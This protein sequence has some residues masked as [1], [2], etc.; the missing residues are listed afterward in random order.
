VKLQLK[1]REL[2]EDLQETEILSKEAE[3][4]LR[5]QRF[6]YVKKQTKR[7]AITEQMEGAHFD[8][9]NKLKKQLEKSDRDLKQSRDN[10]ILNTNVK[11][12]VDLLEKDV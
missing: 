3:S 2:E 5:R 10:S 12:T 11:N 1:I 8:R 7:D 9:V 6:Y 4:A